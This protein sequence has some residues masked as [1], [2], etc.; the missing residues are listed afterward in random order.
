MPFQVIH[1]SFVEYPFPYFGNMVT[2]AD[3]AIVPHLLFGIF[4]VN[5]DNLSY[6]EI[7][8]DFAR[9]IYFAEEHF[10]GGDNVVL[11]FF[12]NSIVRESERSSPDVFL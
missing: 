9:D 2:H 10:Q 7:L 4:L 12:E 11:G 5:H 8:G 1:D 6:F 3:R